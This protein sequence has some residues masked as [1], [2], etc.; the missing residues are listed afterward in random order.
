MKEIFTTAGV[1]PRD[2]LS[3]WHDIACKAFATHECKVA[4]SFDATILWAPLAQIELSVMESNGLRSSTRSERDVARCADD[5]FYLCLQLE[6]GQITHQD[7]RDIVLNAGDFTVFDSR[8]PNA[9]RNSECRNSERWKQIM[10]KIPRSAWTARVG[11]GS[12]LTARTV[13]GSEGAGG[14]ASAF[15]AL[16]PERIGNL[17]PAASSQIAEQVLDLAALALS[18]GAG[19]EA[20]ALSSVKAV[21]VLRLRSV[22]ESRLTN[23]SLDPASVAAAAGISIRYANH[24]L[25]RQGTSLERLILSRRI[26]RCRRA[27]EDS[28]QSHR[29][30]G[31]I[32]YAWGFSDLSH[33]CRRFKS[34]FGL[35]PSDYRRRHQERIAR[36]TRELVG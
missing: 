28:A 18:T 23:P 27:L 1:H 2:R 36:E 6:G 33:F 17:Q 30:I 15:I 9:M 3:Y 19:A 4:S 16:L 7:G 10:L 29:T 22:I 14:L 21:T 35:S 31:D 32:A 8:R 13:L 20:P 24:L 11:S 25:S 26:D 5:A 12:E 34:E